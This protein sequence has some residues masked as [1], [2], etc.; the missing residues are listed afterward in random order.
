VKILAIRFARLGDIILLL[1][2][3]SQLKQSFPG[4]HLTF[5]T[6]HR[7]APVAE[8]CPAID[9][10]ISLDR[11][12]L[13]DGPMLG[14]I[15]EMRRLVRDIK[16]RRFDLVVDFHSFR[17]TN[18][19]AWFSNAPKRVGLK[20]HNA[21]YLSFCFNSPPVI[22]DKMIHVGEMFRRVVGEV[23]GDRTRSSGKPLVLSDELKDWAQQAI[24]SGPRLV[25]YVDAPVPERIWPAE[26]FARLA[27]FAMEKFG[28][29]V[30][31]ISSIEGRHL[32]EH[33][34]TASR[35]GKELS[36][37]TDLTLPQLAALIASSRLLVSNDT[38]PMHFGPAVGV[39]TLGLFSVGYPEHFSPT[40]PRDR[41]LRENP[42]DR[43]EVDSVIEAAEQ[44]WA[45]TVAADPDSRR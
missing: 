40:G 2:A 26:N 43:I 34:R 45:T 1:P 8:L 33:V 19:L 6:G 39:S 21:P 36:L 7:C 4:S 30:A 23:T 10:V 11:I 37:F 15:F 41:V 31:V 16:N 14:S 32:V 29:R 24:P 5:L 28:A 3:L 22:E 17:E 20:R 25:L 44:M 38:G 42:I 9:E 12:A 35:H 18:L 13:R 27:D